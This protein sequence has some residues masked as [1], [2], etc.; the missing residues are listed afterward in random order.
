[1]TSRATRFLDTVLPKHFLKVHNIDKPYLLVRYVGTFLK[2]GVFNINYPSS[3]MARYALREKE[4]FVY[5]DS[6][7]S[8]WYFEKSRQARQN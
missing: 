8:K 6:F 2:R 1:M 4:K 5:H 7:A 3:T